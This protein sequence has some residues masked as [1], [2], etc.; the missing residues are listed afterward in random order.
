[1]SKTIQELEASNIELLSSARHIPDFNVGDSIRVLV[2]SG[3]K[4]SYSCEGVVMSR[5]SKGIASSFLVRRFSGATAVEY[6]FPLYC[7]SIK[8]LEVIRRGIVR[9]AKLNYLRK[10]SSKAARIREAIAPSK[11]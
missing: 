8:K 9:R 7:P 10:L 1:M 11:K 6:S 5:T 4:F 3:D 2:A